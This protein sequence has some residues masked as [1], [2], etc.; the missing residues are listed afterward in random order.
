MPSSLRGVFEHL[1]FQR[2]VFIMEAR[3]EPWIT[4]S[5][6]TVYERILFQQRGNV[7]GAETA[8]VRGILHAEETIAARLSF[9]EVFRAFVLPLKYSAIQTKMTQTPCSYHFLFYVTLEILRHPRRS[10]AY[11]CASRRLNFLR[12]LGDCPLLRALPAWWVISSER[13]RLQLRSPLHPSWFYSQFHTPCVIIVY[14]SATAEC[15]AVVD[16][17]IGIP[18]TSTNVHQC[19]HTF[20]LHAVLPRVPVTCRGPVILC[21]FQKRFCS[22]AKYQVWHQYVEDLTGITEA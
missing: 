22:T 1:N 8:L 21:S 15:D 20:V 14:D 3:S 2:M 6:F 16:D 10:T 4:G 12:S 13:T 7:S 11:P 5:V 17:L 18:V 19:M 9:F